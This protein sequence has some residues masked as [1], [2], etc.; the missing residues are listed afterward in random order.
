[1]HKTEMTEQIEE[2][3]RNNGLLIDIITNP[4][5]TKNDLSSYYDWYILVNNS[6]K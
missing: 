1:V 3:V 6:E 4:S 5:D 2:K